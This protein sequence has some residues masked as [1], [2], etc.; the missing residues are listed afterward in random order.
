MTA[1]K[2]S[3]SRGVTYAMLLTRKGGPMR[4]RRLRRP[5]DARRLR[6]DSE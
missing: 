3:K 6:Q 4:D 1:T 5:K 2:D